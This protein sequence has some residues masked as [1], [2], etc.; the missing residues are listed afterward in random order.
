MAIAK[1]IK[2][3]AVLGTGQTI[4]YTKP[5]IRFLVNAPIVPTIPTSATGDDL[6]TLSALG[7]VSGTASQA[8]GISSGVTISAETIS[9]G[10]ASGIAML[11]YASWKHYFTST[12]TAYKVYG[13]PFVGGVDTQLLGTIGFYTDSPVFEICCRANARVSLIIDGKNIPSPAV[14]VSSITRSGTTA[15]ATVADSGPLAVGQVVLIEGATGADGDF[16]NGVHTVLA[17]PLSTTFTYTMH[18]TPSGSA[19]GTLTYRRTALDIVGVGGS[20]GSS[21]AMGRIVV[22]FTSRKR[23]KVMINI[24]TDGFWGIG[25]GPQD[26]VEPVDFSKEIYANVLSDSYGNS[27]TRLLNFGGPFYYASIFL[28][29][30]AFGCSVGGG[31][32]YD[33]VGTGSSNACSVSSGSA[34]VV[35]T[36]GGNDFSKQFWAIGNP[37]YFTT[38][39]NGF[40][41]NQKLWVVASSTTGGNPD[42]TIQVSLT[43]GGTAISASGTGAMTLKSAGT[44][45]ERAANIAAQSRQADII[46]ISGGVNDG[47]F[48]NA[49]NT[50]SRLRAGAPNAILVVTGPWAPSTAY[51]STAGGKRDSIEAALSAIAGPWVFV[52]NVSGD[53][54]NSKGASGKVGGQSGWQTGNGYRGAPTGSGN[55][56]YYVGPDQ[57]HPTPFGTE[58]L[59]ALLAAATL[60]GIAAL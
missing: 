38:S 32:G 58:Y 48:V 16:Y 50:F 22:T 60:T 13:A 8:T 54:T 41:A 9:A 49:P 26:T 17:K 21:Y 39:A 7:A 14:S 44:F 10:P 5:Q 1:H 47:T 55:G 45:R 53:W 12:G 37:V 35:V 59:G 33:T 3:H 40:T 31:S 36:F 30:N 4:D 11:N 56:D 19:S 29:V 51:Q 57:L 28:G 20:A 23:R 6:P 34:D 27:G 42:Q 52:D 24:S 15:T 18:G 2:E 25:V 43:E 46:F